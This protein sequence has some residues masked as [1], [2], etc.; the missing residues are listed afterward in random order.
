MVWCP[1]DRELAAVF[2]FAHLILKYGYSIDYIW[3]LYDKRITY[4]L[5]Y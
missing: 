2:V 3:R 1:N 4:V 5:L